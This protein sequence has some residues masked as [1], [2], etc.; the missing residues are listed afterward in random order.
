ML[1]CFFKSNK[2]RIKVN[3]IFNAIFRRNLVLRSVEGT[4]GQKLAKPKNVKYR[5]L[6]EVKS[7]INY[8]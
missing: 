2:E 3:G 7:A 8:I 1:Y 4:G 6:F 5:S